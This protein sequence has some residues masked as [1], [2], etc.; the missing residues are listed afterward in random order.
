MVSYE[1]ELF[2]GFVFVVFF[3]SILWKACNNPWIR[4]FHSVVL[5]RKLPSCVNNYILR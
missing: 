1:Q 3:S 5:Q 4:L 2:S